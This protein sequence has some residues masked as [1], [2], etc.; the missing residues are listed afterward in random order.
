[1]RDLLASLNPEQRSAV[2][3]TEGPVLVL[4][5]A[6]TGK[7]RVITHRIAHLLAR[8][9]PAAAILAL[10]FTNKAAGEM[11]QRLR[12]LVGPRRSEGLTA[13]TFHAFCLSVLRANAAALGWP[14]GVSICD[15]SD[16]L[17]A[18]KGVL[19]EL[20][21]SETSARPADIAARISLAKNRLHSPAELSE[22]AVDDADALLARAWERYQAELARTRRVDFDDLLVETVRL[23]RE[24]DRVLSAYREQYRYVMVD[25]YQDT[26]LPQYE[27]VRLL[28][29]SHRNLCVVGDDDQS[30]YGWRGADVTKIL[31]FE[32]DFPGAKVVRLETNYRSTRDIL[33]VANRL[34]AH[35]P[36]R[37]EKKLVSAIG[38]GQLVESV[39]MRDEA[40]EAEHVVREIAERV[41]RGEARF[42]DHAVLF[43]SATQARPFEAELRM[44]QIPY[45][46]VG[47]MSF[48]DRKEVRDVLAYLRLV[49]DPDDESA[50][51]RIVDAPPRGVGKVTLDRVL[52]FATRQGISAGRAFAR[53]NEIEKVPPETAAAVTRLLDRLRAMGERG[54]G[55]L[56]GLVRALLDDVSYRAEV[57]RC[58]PDE[59]TR[60]QRWEG[61]EQVL[62]F[63]ENHARRNPRAE[64]AGFL[65]AVLLSAEDRSE[66]DEA[67]ARDAVV[68]MTLHASKGLEFPRV[69]LVGLEEGLLPHA[70]ALADGSVEEERRLAYVGVTR[71]RAA[72][73]LTWALE[74]AR[75]GTRARV[76]PSRFLLEIKGT[77]PPKDWV[78]YGE[79][80]QPNEQ[81]KKKRARR[82]PR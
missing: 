28:A 25:E 38:G 24:H 30:I 10:T 14:R 29:G 19:R 12:E 48:F 11:R 53:A 44:M 75:H 52:E 60:A 20:H 46:L 80:Q 21:V 35:N 65:D 3:T 23:L 16:R 67:A 2:E 78:P 45:V 37:H 63:A 41:R 66:D 15:E 59:A 17:A 32:R 33:N 36:S 9:V 79:P 73:T 71:A 58:Y 26:N 61:V 7:T 72:L 22:R 27:V 57:E 6:G 34:I 77:P 40:Y 47:G 54:G 42:G 8:R 5:G 51:L 4:A 43:R 1:M 82:A 68:L 39:C 62:D 50:L 64:L 76:H 13:G 31:S 18:I 81:G 49:V 69:Y 74:R 70:R 55:D 56:V